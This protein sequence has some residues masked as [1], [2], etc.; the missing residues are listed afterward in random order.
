MC[1]QVSL[2]SMRRS[3]LHCCGPGLEKGWQLAFFP[4][5]FVAVGGLEPHVDWAVRGATCSPSELVKLFLFARI[6]LRMRV[7]SVTGISIVFPLARM[8]GAKGSSS[9]GSVP[10]TR[11]TGATGGS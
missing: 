6:L 10:P 3:G 2:P 9:G 8:A 1:R 4:V 5:V 7:N 11:M